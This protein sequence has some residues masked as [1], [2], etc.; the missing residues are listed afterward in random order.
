LFEATCKVEEAR[1]VTEEGDSP[2]R[3]ERSKR[4][5]INE[6]GLKRTAEQRREV[7]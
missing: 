2:S 6:L 3:R 4:V 5:G 1:S 7:V